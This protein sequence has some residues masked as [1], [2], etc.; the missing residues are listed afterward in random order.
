MTHAALTMRELHNRES[1]AW[2]S[3]LSPA[4]RTA[5]L[6]RARVRRLFDAESLAL[7]SAACG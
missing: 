1:G 2:F 3:K 6:E 4:L 7:S 5:I